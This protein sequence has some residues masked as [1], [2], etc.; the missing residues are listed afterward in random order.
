M[1]HGY[2]M[3]G[4]GV[5]AVLYLVI[6]ILAARGTI[7]IFQKIFT[8]RSEQIFYAMFLMVIA[9][10][11]LAFSAYFEA[12]TAWRLESVAVVAFAVIGMLGVRLPFALMVGY[13]LHGMWDFVHE[14]QAHG[15]PSLFEPGQLTAIPLAYG[16]FCAAFDFSMAAYFFRRRAEWL[17]AWNA[18]AH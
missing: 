15:G 8:P 3:L 9:A 18:G 10:F 12:T 16:L 6:G 14:L 7:C 4:F 17:A 11:Y 13:S 2:Q 1:G 5:I